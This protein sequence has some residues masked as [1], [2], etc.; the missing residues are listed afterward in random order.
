M[1]KTIFCGC[2]YVEGTG[3]SQQKKEPNLWVNL[4]QGSE[5]L[6]DSELVNV[7]L[8]GRSNQGIFSDAVW[9]LVHD[10]YDYAFVCWTSV[11]RYE[12]ELGL[13]EYVTRQV[14]I[15]NLQ[16]HDHHLNDVVY[17]K[18]YLSKINDRFVSLAHPHFE[19]VQLLFYINSLIK[20]A[21]LV[22]TK[23]FFINSMC[24]WDAGYFNKMENVLPEKY[25]DFTKKNLNVCNRDDDDVFRIYDKMHKEYA[26]T[27]GINEHHW[28]NL[29]QSLRLLLIDTNEDGVHP[30][31]KSNQIF[32]DFLKSRLKDKL[33]A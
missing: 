28:L 10:H 7:G 8:A 24:P 20:L 27:G 15:P 19:I 3:F 13:E 22:G 23:L 1:S 30:G 26:S 4:L 21:D 6:K 31:I 11:P 33:Q 16:M 5:F 9:H 25:T 18:G 12:M 14:F 32:G 29:Y 17:D 2:S